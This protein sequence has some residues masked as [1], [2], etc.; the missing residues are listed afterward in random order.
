MKKK[1]TSGLTFYLYFVQS[2][3]SLGFPL[4]LTIYWVK[5]MIELKPMFL[6]IGKLENVW[7]VLSPKL[8]VS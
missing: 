4:S 7:R 3:R 1:K 8:P 2:I 6:G 5:S